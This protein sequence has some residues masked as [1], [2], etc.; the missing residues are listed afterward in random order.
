MKED[1]DVSDWVM[2]PMLILGVLI[3]LGVALLKSCS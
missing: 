2:V 3:T 1:R